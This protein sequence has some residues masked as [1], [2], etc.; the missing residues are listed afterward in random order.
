MIEIVDTKK[1]QFDVVDLDIDLGMKVDP[2]SMA[3]NINDATKTEV[4]FKEDYDFSKEGTVEV[5][6]Q[7]K[8]KGNN[9]TEKKGK[10]KVTKDSEPPQITGLEPL[11]IVIGAKTDY[12]SG[13]SISD[14]RDPEPKFN[15]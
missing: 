11:T 13:V 6:I 4:S 15:G 3:T 7:V 12:N 8:D 5:I 14:N 2:A 9:V 1:P 10:V